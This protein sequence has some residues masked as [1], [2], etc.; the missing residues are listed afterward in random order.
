MLYKADI[1]HKQGFTPKVYRIRHS[2]LNYYI[3]RLGDRWFLGEGA[4]GILWGRSPFEHL[5]Y[6][7]Q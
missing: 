1:N 2:L 7:M 6:L 3:S 5:I 4:I